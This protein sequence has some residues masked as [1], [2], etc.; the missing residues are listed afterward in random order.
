[1]AFLLRKDNLIFLW[2]NPKTLAY[3]EQKQHILFVPQ[4]RFLMVE[5]GDI[6]E[7]IWKKRTLLA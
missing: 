5:I 3:W 7:P 6:W 4:H 2:R 1:V